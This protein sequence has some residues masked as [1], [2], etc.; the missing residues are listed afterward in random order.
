MILK[1]KAKLDSVWVIS[2][3][4]VV[5]VGMITEHSGITEVNND[6]SFYNFSG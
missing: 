3:I 2:G 1:R 4:K 5:K 6:V